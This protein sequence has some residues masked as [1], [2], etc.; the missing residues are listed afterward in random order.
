MEDTLRYFFSAVFQGFAAIIT[1]GIMFYLYYLDKLTK[2][3]ESIESS[4]DGHIPSRGTE[5][6]F[7]VKENGIVMYVKNKVLPFKE[8][9]AGY[10]YIR[11]LVAIYE[12][13]IGQKEKL[14]INLI[15]LFKIAVSILLTTLMSL[16]CVGYFMW[17]NLTL[18]VCGIIIIILSWVF[19]LKLFSF[20]SEII[21]SPKIV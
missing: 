1:L 15:A 9:N 3:L 6:D 17:L 19:F 8:G 12:V 2:K 11:K 21:K 10:D 5:G 14:N 18:F 20:I 4:F 7:Y 16:F 13:N